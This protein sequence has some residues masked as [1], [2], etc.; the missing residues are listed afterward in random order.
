MNHSTCQDLKFIDERQAVEDKYFQDITCCGERIAT[1][2]TLMEHHERFHDLA[3]F[4]ESDEEEEVGGGFPSSLR[5]EDVFLPVNHHVGSI[6]SKP[7]EP[8]LRFFTGT[9][10][11]ISIDTDLLLQP[12]KDLKMPSSNQRPVFDYVQKKPTTPLPLFDF[13]QKNPHSRPIVVQIQ[14]GKPH[15]Y[16]KIITQSCI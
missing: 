3:D 8:S 13:V 6:K 16:S 2:H 11:C 5:Y 10:E 4:R 12:G 15:T 14:E 7:R 1:L 9:Q